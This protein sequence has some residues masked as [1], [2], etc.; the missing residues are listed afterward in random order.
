MVDLG[1]ACRNYIM[2]TP[3]TKD[4]RTAAAGARKRFIRRPPVA[5]R[6]L[7]RKLRTFVRKWLG[8]HLDPLS[9]N[10]DSRVETWLA[11]T[12]YSEARKEE[13]RVALARML[14]WDDPDKSNKRKHTE[15][16]AFVKAESYSERKHCRIINARRDAAKALFGPFFKLIEFELYDVLDEHGSTPFIKHVPVSDRPRY[17]MDRVYKGDTGK[18]I[19]TDY[20]AFESL[21]TADLMRY[22]EKELYVYMVECLPDGEEFLSMFEKLIVGQNV[23]HFAAFQLVVEATRMSGEMNTS[24]GNGFANLMLMLFTCD[25]HGIDCVGCVEGD[26]GIFWVSK[27]LPGD[28][29]FKSLGLFIKIEYH[30]DIS[31]A[32]FCGM[33]FD[34]QDKIVVTDPRKVLAS[35]GWARQQYLT[36][37]DTTLKQLLRMKALSFAHQYKGCPI[38]GA[39]SHWILRHTR[40]VRIR[41]SIKHPRDWWTRQLYDQISPEGE[42]DYVEPPT[43]TRLLVASQFGISVTSQLMVER[44]FK[45]NPLQSIPSTL[46]MHFMPDDWAVFAEG[47]AREADPTRLAEFI[48]PGYVRATDPAVPDQDH[49]IILARNK[50]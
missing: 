4:A 21:F 35:I 1:V 20:T 32:S 11:T 18:Y 46:I 16:G 10:L 15:V 30:D 43:R 40:N 37:K 39:L 22:V 24:L 29:W 6:R 48:R 41:K 8:R 27:E 26:D 47:Y 14:A 23:C 45:E 31:T 42:L 49:Q 5:N 13:I 19:A 36:A 38:V 34:T 33:I 17:L 2:L 3:S 28:A 12:N 50:I 44:W 9:W 7:L 25:E